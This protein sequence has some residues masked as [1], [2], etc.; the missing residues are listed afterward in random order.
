M[1]KLNDMQMK[2]LRIIFDLDHRVITTYETWQADKEN[3]EL[4]QEWEK[5]EAEYAHVTDAYDMIGL[6]TP[7]DYDYYLNEILK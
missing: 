7:E 1:K 4:E 3:K 2:A 5:A 6:I